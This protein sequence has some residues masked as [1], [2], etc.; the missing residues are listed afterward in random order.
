MATSGFALAT[1]P[2][3]RLARGTIGNSASSLGVAMSWEESAPSKRNCPCGIGLYLVIDR[4]DD[5]GRHDE[6]WEMHCSACREEYGLFSQHYNRKGMSCT[7]R[8]WVRKEIID[9]LHA[10]F[11]RLE[12]AKKKLADR[13]YSRFRSVW[14]DHF[15]RKTKKATWSELTENGKRYPSLST[16]YTHVRES[17]LDDVL[18]GYFRYPSLQTVIRVLKVRDSDFHAKLAEIGALEK[19]HETKESRARQLAFV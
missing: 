18:E 8:G 2:L 17:S 16:F 14:I 9:D 15:H 1:R 10:T 12:T 7:F 6:R 11:V 19:E 4:S 13:M 3:E 5:W